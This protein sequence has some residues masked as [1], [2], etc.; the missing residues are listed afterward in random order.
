MKN[1]VIQLFLITILV[2]GCTSTEHTA[3]TTP[4]TYKGLTARDAIELSESAAP[5]N[6]PGVFSVFIKASGNVN[7]LIYLNTEL[8][9]RDRRNVS[10]VLLPEFQKAFLKKYGISAEEMLM[11]KNIKV[12]SFATRTKIV[13]SYRGQPT[14]K[15][16]FQTHIPVRHLKQ[17]EFCAKCT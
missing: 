6:A 14:S 1:K 13:F 3:Q 12:N 15:Y 8:D 10:I 9:Y 17:I 11:N 5:R 4:Q 7:K 16:Y 2:S